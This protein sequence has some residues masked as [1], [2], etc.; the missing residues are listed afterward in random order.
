LPAGRTAPSTTEHVYSYTNDQQPQVLWYHDHAD[1]NTANHVSQGLFGFYLLEESDPRL[2]AA[3]PPRAY[4]VPLGL[5]VLSGTDATGQTEQFVALNGVHNPVFNVEPRH[6]RFRL[7]NASV[8]QSI[9]LVLCDGAGNRIDAVTQ[10]GSDGGLMPVPQPRSHI[11]IFQAERYDV[12]LDLTSRAGQGPL[13]LYG[14]IKDARGCTATPNNVCRVVSRPIMQLTVDR[15]LT[16]TDQTRLDRVRD[17]SWNVDSEFL[18]RQYCTQRG[19][20]AGCPLVPDRVLEFDITPVEADGHQLMPRFRIN[21]AAYSKFRPTYSGVIDPATGATV[22]YPQVINPISIAGNTVEVWQL[23]NKIGCIAHPIHIH[24][25]EFQIV[26]VDGRAVDPTQYG[27]KDVFVLRP[28][29]APTCF[30]DAP[31]APVRTV[32]VI[33]YFEN[34]WAPTDVMDS[35]EELP[36]NVRPFTDAQNSVSYWK[37]STSGVYVFHCHNLQHEDDAM[38]GQMIVNPPPFVPP[39]AR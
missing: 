19:L 5:Q 35:S 29:A 39:P 38:M 15:P 3:L 31:T 28:L 14:A 13:Y 30:Q 20:P 36:N 4:D 11:E 33:G 23:V 2:V 1:G 18:R 27:W 17:P 26:E 16:G 9:D 22:M 21:E 34:S 7:L 25:I 8:G 12:V 37:S 6:Y 10:I 32:T 24:D